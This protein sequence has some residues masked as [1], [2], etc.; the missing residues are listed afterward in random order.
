M[1]AD[2]ENEGMPAGGDAMPAMERAFRTCIIHIYIYCSILQLIVA[3]TLQGRPSVRRATYYDI[4]PYRLGVVT[5]NCQPVEPPECQAEAVVHL[6]NSSPQQ[7]NGSTNHFEV[8]SC[9]V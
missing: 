2:D 1:N 3:Y 5:V 9:L 8:K 6:S 4:Y 7:C